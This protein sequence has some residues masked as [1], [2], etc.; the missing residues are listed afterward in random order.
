MADEKI[1]ALPALTTPAV[2]DLLAIVD[3]PAGTPITKKIALSDLMK[4]RST[5]VAVHSDG[6]A[7]ITMTN[8][9]NSEQF[10]GNSNRN[11]TKIDLTHYTQVRLI[12]RVVTNSA[13]ANTPRVYAEYHT[14]FTT[15]VG[16][17]SDIGSSAVNCSLASTGVIDSGWIDLVAGA[18]AD[19][20]VTVLQNGGDGAADPAVGGVYLH[21][22]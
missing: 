19:V 16:T 5:V 13:S 14:S 9:P 18:K 11:I 21:F 17:F 4:M 15:T 8:Q 2:V 22:R 10:L 12:T 1:T 3:D 6:S 7:N 20:F